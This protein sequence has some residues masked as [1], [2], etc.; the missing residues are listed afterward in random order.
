MAA[1][2]RA[3]ASLGPA[4]ASCHRR[5]AALGCAHISRHPLRAA[6]HN[7]LNI[8]T[9]IVCLT[10][11]SASRNR[12]PSTTRGA[13]SVKRL[14]VFHRSS[15]PPLRDTRI[16]CLNTTS[17]KQPSLVGSL[18]QP[19]PGPENDVFTRTR[20]WRSGRVDRPPAHVARPRAAGR[21]RREAAQL[22]GVMCHE[23]GTS[24]SQEP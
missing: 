10:Q 15:G 5:D 19:L 24:S 9:E 21:P 4:P 1:A 13:R 6:C 20:G 17:M 7:L 2:R 3:S 12:A 16:P 11:T 18:D 22:R 14:P 23:R 8:E